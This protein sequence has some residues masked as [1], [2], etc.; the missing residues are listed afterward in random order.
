M[1]MRTIS[2]RAAVGL[3]G[4]VLVAMTGLLATPAAYGAPAGGDPPA[5]KPGDCYALEVAS[6]T[7]PKQLDPGGTGTIVAKLL[8]PNAAGT[9]DDGM[10]A[11]IT[12]NGTPK[13]IDSIDGGPDIVCGEADGAFAYQ[14]RCLAAT[15][16]GGATATLTFRI[17][18]V[19]KG[20]RIAIGVSVLDSS[21]LAIRPGKLAYTDL[22]V[23]VPAV[24]SAPTPTP[25][26]PSTSE[27]ATGQLVQRGAGGQNV[28]AI[29][30]LLRHHGSA[31]EAD[32]DFGE[33]TDAAVRSF[34]KAK[35]LTVD[36]VV[37]PQTWGALWVTLKQGTTGSDAV[38]ALQTLLTGRGHAVEIDG[39]FGPET[40]AA[41]K[42]FQRAKKLPEDG[43]AGTRTWTALVAGT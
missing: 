16:P 22:M 7:G 34:Q 32:G 1:T 30:Y 40:E 17:K 42:A 24:A 21:K 23:T 5:Y 2:T 11:E 20:D 15:F 4:V 8:N 12:F 25:A 38:L 39:Y 3:V 6:L 41:V 26:Q 33:Q 43:I 9:C 36:G 18:G 13:A 28:E 29:Q 19:D 31:V 10:Q 14:E 35:G 27:P 37:G